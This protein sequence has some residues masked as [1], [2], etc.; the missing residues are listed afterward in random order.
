MSPAC[1]ETSSPS[2][3]ICSGGT[4]QGKRLHNVLERFAGTSHGVL[5][6]T[7]IV[8]LM[9]TADARIHGRLSMYGQTRR[10][11]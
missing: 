3:A 4:H 9:L 5:F 8:T 7:A 1:L 6:G 11:F 2:G 10:P